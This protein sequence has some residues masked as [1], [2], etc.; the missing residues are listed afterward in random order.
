[1]CQ[2]SPKKS[3]FT[4][5]ELLVVIAIIAILA[6]MLLPALARAKQKALQIS[7]LNNF[8]QM[9]LGWVLYST[10]NSDQLVSND[11]FATG[12]TVT[13]PTL[14]TYWCPGNIQI[15]AQGASEDYIKVGTLYP[16][17]NS[18]KAYH[19]PG[20]KT[21]LMFGGSNRDRVRSYSLSLFMNGNNI[22]AASYGSMFINAHKSTDVRIAT[23][24]IV[25]CE[26]G[27]TL[28]DGQFGFDPKLSTDAGFSGWSWVNVPAFYH[29]ASTAFSFADGHGEMHRWVDP[30][31]RTLTGAGAFQ[32]DTSGNHNDIT[33][34]KKHIAGR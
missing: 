34:L 18:T 2:T 32:A 19:C 5:I 33:W 15:P 4:L 6:A 28:D 27:A 7:C 31:T 21:Q 9:T 25:F 11:R 8:K 12:A 26:E 10:D 22:E 23:D 20:D 17:I 1:M 3:A 13:P 14:S 30:Q 29:G 24:T 16:Q